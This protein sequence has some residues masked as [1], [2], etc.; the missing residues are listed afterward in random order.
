VDCTVSNRI[1]G[2]YLHDE[3]GTG[4]EL[5]TRIDFA[6]FPT[7]T[8]FSAV[9]AVGDPQKKLWHSDWPDGCAKPVGYST[10]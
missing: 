2:V 7:F 1:T 4:I 3:N 10:K 5:E 6:V 9:K 8:N